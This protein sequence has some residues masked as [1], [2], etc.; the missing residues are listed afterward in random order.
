M[1]IKPMNIKKNLK[2]SEIPQAKSFYG[3]IYSWKTHTKILTDPKN[4]L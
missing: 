4:D 2:T 3:P 1:D